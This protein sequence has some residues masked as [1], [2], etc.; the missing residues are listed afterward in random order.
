MHDD[1]SPFFISP[2]RFDAVDDDAGPVLDRRH[3][4]VPEGG[5]RVLGRY[6]V[7]VAGHLLSPSET[8]RAWALP[9]PVTVTVTDHRVTYV[10]PGS[11]LALVGAGNRRG[12]RMPGLV[13]G[14]IR[15]QWPSR[16]EVRAATES[17]PARLLVVCDALRTIQQPALALIGPAAQIDDLA[18]QVRHAVATFRLVRP[19]L[20]DLSPPERDA[21]A[22][23][24]RVAPLAGAARVLLPGSLPIEFHS[25]DD[26]YR[27]RHSDPLPYGAVSGQQ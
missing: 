17:R 18:R 11:Q 27:P 12:S 15:W 7:D 24:A 21:L 19:E 6:R 8:R 9:A 10:G 26:Y 23:L 14:Q 16:L 2:H 3:E 13:S 22:R 20:V 25:R 5:E 4:L 1:A